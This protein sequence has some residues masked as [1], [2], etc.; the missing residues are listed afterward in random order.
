MD[1]RSSYFNRY[2]AAVGVFLCLEKANHEDEACITSCIWVMH[3]VK[4]VRARGDT[5]KTG[6]EG[7]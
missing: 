3:I 2:T 4:S 7:G 5:V 6:D 1:G